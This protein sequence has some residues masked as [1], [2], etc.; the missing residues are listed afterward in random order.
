MSSDKSLNNDAES[1]KQVPRLPNTENVQPYDNYQSFI[2]NGIWSKKVK[3]NVDSSNQ[4]STFVIPNGVSD[5]AE[6]SK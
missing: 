4:D 5:S 6:S 1:R 3:A 2:T